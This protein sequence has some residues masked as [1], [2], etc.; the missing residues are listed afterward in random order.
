M[1]RY[2]LEAALE[3]K[4]DFWELYEQVGHI[5]DGFITKRNIRRTLDEL[6]DAALRKMMRA[7][8]ETWIML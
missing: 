6:A 8:R 3:N 4:V 1:G 7:T 2:L 5:V